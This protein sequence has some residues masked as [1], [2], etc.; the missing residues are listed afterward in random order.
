MMH[1]KRQGNPAF[2]FLHKKQP[3]VDTLGCFYLKGNCYSDTT[4]VLSVMRRTPVVIVSVAT[5]TAKTAIFM[6]SVSFF[7]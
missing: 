6:P 4:G 5:I 1:N 7:L 3:S 2:Y